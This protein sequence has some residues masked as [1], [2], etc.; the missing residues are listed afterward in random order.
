[1]GGNW[2]Y[3]IMIDRFNN[4]D[5]LP[6]YHPWDGKHGVF[7]GGSFK[8]IFPQILVCPPRNPASML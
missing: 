6:K 3:F 4:P 8:G 2:I 7:Q 1:M 5:L